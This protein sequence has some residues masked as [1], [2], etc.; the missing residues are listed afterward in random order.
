MLKVTTSVTYSYEGQ[1]LLE[2]ID[3][4]SKVVERSRWSNGMKIQARS[5][6][7]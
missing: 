4:V 2:F 5:T 3:K 6:V 7:W 1:E